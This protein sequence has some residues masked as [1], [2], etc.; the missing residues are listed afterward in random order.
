MNVLRPRASSERGID[1]FSRRDWLLSATKH[2]FDGGVAATAIAANQSSQLTQIGVRAHIA[3]HTSYRHEIG[4]PTV[5]QQSAP[6]CCFSAQAPI[7]SR[8]VPSLC[9][10]EPFPWARDV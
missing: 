6:A 7:W 3:A 10:S 9:T 8:T 2:A 1:N 4:D 5:S